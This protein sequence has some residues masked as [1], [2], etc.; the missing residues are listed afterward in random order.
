MNLGR[1]LQFSSPGCYAINTGSRV[2]V[3]EDLNNNG[4]PYENEEFLYA[5][6]KT[7]QLTICIIP[8]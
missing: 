7:N 3:Y 5:V 4:D 8:R 6:E 2:R 1:K